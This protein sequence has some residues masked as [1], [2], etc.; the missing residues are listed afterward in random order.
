[1]PTPHLKRALGLWDLVFYGIVLITITAPLPILGIISNEAKGHVS[2]TILIAMVAMLFTAISYGRMAS[3]YP[4]AGSA[5]S[6]VGRSINPVRIS[7]RLGNGDGL[8]AQPHFMYNLEQQ[9]LDEH[10]TPSSHSRFA[11]YSLHCCLL[12]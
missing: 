9:G 5:F 10:F 1:M 12:R 8:Y 4:L 2:L 7:Y 6:Y 11:R 3:V